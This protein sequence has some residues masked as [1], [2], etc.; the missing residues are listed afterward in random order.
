MI[1]DLIMP[2]REGIETIRCILREGAGTPIIAISGGTLT[3]TADFLAMA[4]ELGATAILRKPFEPIELLLL[5]ER[6]L[7]DE[8]RSTNSGRS[9][10]LNPHHLPVPVILHNAGTIRHSCHDQASDCSNRRTELWS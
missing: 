8:F 10:G 3:G 1:T 7:G 2:E 5:V 9:R 4:R 6:C